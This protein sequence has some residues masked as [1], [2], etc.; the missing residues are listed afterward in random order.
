MEYPKTRLWESRRYLKW[1]DDQPCVFTGRESTHH[2]TRCLGTGGIGMKP[3]DSY[4]LPV[5][6]VRIHASIHGGSGEMSTYR[7]NIPGGYVMSD[8]EI[9]GWVARKCLFYITKYLS[10]CRGKA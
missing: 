2:H 1:I 4:V 6:Q 3:S 7:K 8:E 9:L 5:N 10:E